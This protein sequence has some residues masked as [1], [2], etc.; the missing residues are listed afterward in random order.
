[1]DQADDNELI[2]RA[3]A[4][5]PGDERAFAE[6]VRRHEAHVRA[7]CRYIVGNDEATDDLAQEVF[8]RAY[9][10]LSS[11]EGRSSFGTWVRRIKVNHCLNHVSAAGRWDTLDIEGGQLDGHPAMRTE[12]LGPRLLEYEEFQ[13]KVD[14]VLRSMPDTLRIALVLRDMDGLSQQEVAR[15]L[16]ISLSAA[17]MR[18][19]R[20]RDAFRDAW[21]ALEEARK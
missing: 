9:F 8:I 11:F 21:A 4:S 18:I 12:P 19:M 16:D 3:R 20:G 17:K 14:Q 2:E 5:L 6:L 15:T 1:M 10:G 7:N 13:L